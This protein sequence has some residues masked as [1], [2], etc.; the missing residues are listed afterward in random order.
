VARPELARPVAGASEAL[1]ALV[2]RYRV[3]G[4]LTG[5]RAEEVLALLPVRGL[6]I[7]GL[8]GLQGRAPELAAVVSAQVRAAADRIQ[9]AWV[10]DKQISIAVHYRQAPD[11]RAARAELLAAL[12][13]IATENGLELVE[14][15]MVLELV[16]PDRPMKGGALERLAGRHEL[17]GVLYAGDDRA[18]L[19]AFAG[20]DR[21][22]AHGVATV[23]VAVRGPETPED[24]LSAADVVV[25]GPTGL[26]ELLGQLV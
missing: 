15:K 7:L 21:L 20:L 14:G 10:D 26:V 12:Q 19:D 5:R 24:L 13:P 6:E 17:R 1:A 3:V 16:P 22:A 18:D 23:R 25:E 2:P 8:Y 4:V 11:P 9:E